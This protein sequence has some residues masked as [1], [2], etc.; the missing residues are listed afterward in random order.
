MIFVRA[1]CDYLEGIVD[2]GADLNEA[3][4]KEEKNWMPAPNAHWK[5]NRI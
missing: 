1:R 4:L 5:L 3:D 2:R